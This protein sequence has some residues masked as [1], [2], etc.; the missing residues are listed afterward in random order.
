MSEAHSTRATR[1]SKPAKPD[2]KSPLFAHGC[3]QW[4]KKIRGRFVYFGPWSDPGA[5][6]T[7]YLAEKDALH[8]GR[9]PRLETEAVKV[10]DA[11]NAFL[12]AKDA[13]LRLVS[14]RPG[15]APTTRW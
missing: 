8:A 7:K 15:P 3:G 14:Y 5:A 1:R 11:C 13:C 9:K 4:C 12:N 2:P 10:K 6:L